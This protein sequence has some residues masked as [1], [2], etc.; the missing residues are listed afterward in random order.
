MRVVTFKLEEELLQK[1]DLYAVNMRLS[2]SE[3]IR[4]A[5]KSF[6]NQLQDDQYTGCDEA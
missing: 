6:L 5:I 2:R 4:D 3:V 1:L